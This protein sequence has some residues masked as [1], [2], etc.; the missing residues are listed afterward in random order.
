MSDVIKVCQECGSK[1]S[2]GLTQCDICGADVMNTPAT[3]AAA[4]ATEAEGSVDET[5]SQPPTKTTPS[6]AVAPSSGKPLYCVSCGALNEVGDAFC[7]A[8]GASLKRPAQ[9]KSR[10]KASTNKQARTPVLFSTRQWSAI[11]AAAFLLGAVITAVLYPSF[12]TISSMELATEAP[13]QGKPRPTLEQ[14]DALRRAAEANPADMNAQLRYANILHD[15]MLLDQAIA[16][17]KQYLEKVP[18]DVNARVDLGICYFEQE[19]YS[20]AIAEMEA[21]LKH[22]PDHQLGNYNLG[23]VNYNAGNIAVA[24]DWFIRARN[25]NPASPQGQNAA[26]ILQEIESAAS[27]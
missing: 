17:Y 14:V 7:H 6:P 22:E 16:Q 18:E 23:I 15:A 10:K 12:A 27:P 9:Q 8:C 25:I 4:S 26:R 24:K 3:E 2:H 20:E 21:A 11:T 19:K 5:P 1:L 13:H